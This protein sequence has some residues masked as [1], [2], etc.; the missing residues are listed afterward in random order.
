MVQKR[1]IG[2]LVIVTIVLV[3]IPALASAAGGLPT[4]IVQ[5]G[6]AG[7][8][9]CGLCDIATLAQNVLNT[10]IFIAVF[11][12]A[13]LFAWAGWKYVTAGGG[14]DVSAAREIFTNVLVGLVIILAAWLIVDTIMR[15]LV[16]ENATIG[17]WNK[18]C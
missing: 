14:G 17:P 6:S 4:R 18:M 15:T 13:I 11:L 1:A 12:S 5:C 2:L 3:A 8:P 16:N 9:A 7:Q 10:G